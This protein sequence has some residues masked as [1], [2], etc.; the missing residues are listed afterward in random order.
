MKTQAC[1][2]AKCQECK[3]R[4]LAPVEEEPMYP[5]SKQSTEEEQTECK[6]TKKMPFVH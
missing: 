1:T 3:P 4:C 5:Q 2:P 6:S